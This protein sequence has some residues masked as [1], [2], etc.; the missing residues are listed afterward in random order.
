MCAKFLVFLTCSDELRF[1]NK[2]TR[3]NSQFHAAAKGAFQE[4]FRRAR[5]ANELH[6]AFSLAPEFQPCRLTSAQDATV[7]FRDYYDFLVRYKGEPIQARIALAFYC[8]VAEASGFW[9]IPKNLLNILNGDIYNLS[10]FSQFVSRHLASGQ[11][12]APNANKVL[13][14]LA[15]AAHDVGLHQVAEVFRDAFD[16]DLRNAY[17]HADYALAREGIFVRGRYDT[18][19]LISWPEFNSL[20]DRGVNVHCV[21]MEVLSE[22]MREYRQRKIVACRINDVDPDGK[23]EIWYDD[24][25]S[26][27]TITG[28]FGFVS[29]S[30]WFDCRFCS[31]H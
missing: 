4:L 25:K 1:R 12:I 31:L 8:H 20:L 23:Y 21:L 17:A 29:D 27:L 13:R 24:V 15:G 7:A 16:A 5:S 9:E 6:F 22:F 2:V 11:T 3:C 19:R 26:E 10:P 14:S 18:E 30:E 28:T